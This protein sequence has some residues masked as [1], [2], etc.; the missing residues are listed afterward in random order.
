LSVDPERERIS[1]GIKQLEKDPFSNFVAEHGKGSFVK[2]T[3]KEVDAKA[4][5]IDLG[6][7]IDGTLRASELS[8]DRIEDA[9]TILSVGDEV[10][11]KFMGVDRK[12]RAIMLS[13]KAKDSADEAA[14]MQD[15]G[16]GSAEATTNL[17]DVLKQHL[18]GDES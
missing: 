16:S 13:V 9:R 10:E 1:L 14:M 18:N 3:V 7:G 8:R 2:G 15:Y 6:D 5:I 12:S 11:A 4:A 17:G